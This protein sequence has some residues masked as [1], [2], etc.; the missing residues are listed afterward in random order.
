MLSLKCKSLNDEK[1]QT[2]K[3]L[4][5]KSKIQIKYKL[6]WSTNTRKKLSNQ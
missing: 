3:E 1:C 5:E 2:M 6:S 4:L